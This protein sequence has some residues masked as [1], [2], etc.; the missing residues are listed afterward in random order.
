MNLSAPPQMVQYPH[1]PTLMQALGALLNMSVS[2]ELREEIGRR[3]AVKTLLGECV[4]IY[5]HQSMYKT[6]IEMCRDVNEC[7]AEILKQVICCLYNVVLGCHSNVSLLLE[8]RGG[9]V[10]ADL[11]SKQLPHKVSQCLIKLV[12]TLPS[13]K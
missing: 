3:G 11:L 13:S 8:A 6:P 4:H 5:C 7:D 12:Q 9:R 10:L 2:A 1:K